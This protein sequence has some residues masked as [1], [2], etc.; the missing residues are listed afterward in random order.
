L[1]AKLQNTAPYPSEVKWVNCFAPQ[2]VKQLKWFTY[3]VLSSIPCRDSTLLLLSHGMAAACRQ[4]V[5]PVLW[6]SSYTDTQSIL[7]ESLFVSELDGFQPT[8]CTILQ[9]KCIYI[10]LRIS[11]DISK[12]CTETQPKTPNSKQ[13]RCWSTLARKNSL[14]RPKPRK[15]P[16]GTRLCRVASPLLAVPGGDYNRTWPRCSNVH[17]WPAWSNNRSGTGS[18]SGEQVRVP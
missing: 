11:A 2:L 8:Q 3:Q 10:A 6:K 9:I 16:R 5:C 4:S 7:N 14:E 1:S 13:C 18:M 12:F 15:K 17:K